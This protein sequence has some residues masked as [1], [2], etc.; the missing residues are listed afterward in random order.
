VVLAQVDY[1]GEEEALNRP[2]HHKFSAT[3]EGSSFA[4]IQLYGLAFGRLLPFKQGGLGS[5]SDEEGTVL[6]RSRNPFYIGSIFLALCLLFKQKRPFLIPSMDDGFIAV[7]GLSD[8]RSAARSIELMCSEAKKDAW[9][10]L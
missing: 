8:K 10:K 4:K 5:G 3:I 6:P 7:S 2:T 1:R 9:L